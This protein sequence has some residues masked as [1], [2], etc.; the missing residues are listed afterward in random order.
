MK[1]CREKTTS[2]FLYLAKLSSSWDA[3]LPNHRDMSIRKS[4]QTQALFVWFLGCTP[5][6]SYPN[7]SSSTSLRYWIRTYAKKYSGESQLGIFGSLYWSSYIQRDRYSDVLPS[8]LLIF[9]PSWDLRSQARSFLARPS[10]SGSWTSWG[11]A[12]KHQ[13]RRTWTR[14]AK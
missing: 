4:N 13:N 8:H 12:L 6:L 7:S 10:V 3:A 1:S 5:C 9:W 11:P 2:S 14:I